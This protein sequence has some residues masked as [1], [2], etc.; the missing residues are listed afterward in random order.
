L[1]INTFFQSPTIIGDLPVDA[2]IVANTNITTRIIARENCSNESITDIQILAFTGVQS[3][4]LEQLTNSTWY[5]NM[6]WTPPTPI[7]GVNS[8][9]ICSTA[10][11]T[12]LLSSASSCFTFITGITSPQVVNSTVSPTGVTLTTTLSTQTQTF[13]CSFNVDVIKPTSSSYI[14][15]YSA[16]TNQQVYALDAS[17]S[18]T[19]QFTS[20][21][22]MNFIV[23]IGLLSSGNYYI[24][25]DWG[26]II[27]FFY[28]GLFKYLFIYF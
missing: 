22:D 7:V 15:I 1:N 11:D 10:T 25:F 5:K 9:L 4:S 13:S 6:T 21:T 16:S 20:A 23:P 27:I 2:C 17:L 8:Y 12:A 26:K 3:S 24:L 14:R 18:N 19:I 28:Y